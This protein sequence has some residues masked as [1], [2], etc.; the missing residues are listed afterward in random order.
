MMQYPIKLTKLIFSHR[1][2]NFTDLQVKKKNILRFKLQ[3][4]MYLKTNFMLIGSEFIAI[5]DIDELSFIYV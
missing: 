3:M 5:Y 2:V 4:F 1:V